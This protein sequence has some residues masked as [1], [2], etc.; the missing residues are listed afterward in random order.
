MKPYLFKTSDFGR[1]W[2]SLSANL[3]QDVYL[4]AVREDP[5]R[6]GMLYAGTE[7][8]VAF[9][10]DDGATWQQLRLNL[11][12]VAVHDLQV[13]NNDLVLGTHGRS[14]WIFDNL[15]ALRGMSPQIAG[16]DVHLFS[17]PPAIRWHYHGAFHR[18][19]NGQNPPAG[20]L[21][22]YYLKEKPKGQIQLEI[23]D[24]GGGLV[25]TLTSKP[26]K[27]KEDAREKT[28]HEEE[29]PEDDPDPPYERFKKTR[30]T[31]EHGV[32]RVAWDLRYKGADKIK[33]AKVDAGVPELGPLVNPGTYTL[34]LTVGSKSVTATVQVLPDPRIQLSP[35]ILD[36]QLK[37]ALKI[38]DDLTR[39]ARLVEEI[40]TIRTQLVERDKL[41]KDNP[42]VSAL[43]KS[44]KDLI[45]KLN[46]LEETLHNPK[47]QVTYDILAQRGGAKLYSQLSYLF[48]DAKEAGPPTQGDQQ[49]YAEQAA[50]LQ[51]CE[52]ELGEL[53]K[54]DLTRLNT[55]AKSLAIPDI[56]VPAGVQTS[57]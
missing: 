45:A 35:S 51:K 10:T 24:A 32:N 43:T 37:F 44:S 9:S 52:K 36:E 39:L 33:G 40:R 53:L 12:A 21:I 4:H 49:I 38:R 5:L 47:A 46:A 14:V 2:K 29:V 54:G 8:G 25:D 17:V 18:K 6:K 57:K 31:T 48:D 23:H 7:R 34:K 22:D 20:A 11:P 42:K 19:G 41:L 15:S 30:L 13:K 50:V 27:D 16:E 28:L 3:P 1:T 26:K 56:L 55:L